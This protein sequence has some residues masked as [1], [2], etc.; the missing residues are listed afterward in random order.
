LGTAGRFG[1]GRPRRI[2]ERCSATLRHLTI[3]SK[4]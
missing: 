3:W 2:D 1:I 4:L